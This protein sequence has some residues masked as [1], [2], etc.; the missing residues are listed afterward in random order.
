MWGQAYTHHRVLRGGSWNNNRNNVRA[1][2]RNRNNPDNRNR[3]N[4]FRVVVFT[5]F[6]KCRN[7]GA[8]WGQPYGVAQQFTAEARKM[9]GL[10]PVRALRPDRFLETCQVCPSRTYNNVPA[11]WADC[12]GAGNLG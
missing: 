11:P 9:A 10:V 5:F 4:G 6:H 2:Y 1:A 12:L 7:C 8:V 3:N